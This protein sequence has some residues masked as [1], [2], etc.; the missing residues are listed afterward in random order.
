MKKKQ[1][2]PTQDAS[3]EKTQATVVGILHKQARVLLED[4]VASCLLPASLMTDRNAL[5]VGDRVELRPATGGQY[6]LI[7]VLPRATALYRGDRR[8]PDQE[9]LIAANARYL[10]VVVS[11]S[12]LLH[13]AGYIESALIAAGRAKMQ[14]AI[15]ISRWDLIDPATE[16]LLQD[17]LTLYRR[18]CSLV[19]TDLSSD[20]LAALKGNTTVLVGDRGWGK[21]SVIR[22]ILY[23]L[24]DQPPAKDP[25][26]TTHSS[27]LHA[28][29]DGT[30]LIDTPGFRDF[31]LQELTQEERSA[32]FPEIAEQGSACHFH[33]CSHRHEEGC[34]VI[35]GL[36]SNTLRRDRYDAYQKLAGTAPP[37]PK[38]DYR[39]RPC[40]ES[41]VCKACGNPVS[42]EGAGSQHRNHCP[43]C[44]CSLHVDEQTGDR[45]AVCKGIME[46]IGVWVRK[47]GEW[48][49][50]HR[51]R[52]CGALSSN[53]IAA[54]DNPA[55]LL[56]IAVKPLAMTPFPL[57]K[58]EE[59]FG[60]KA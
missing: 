12:Y 35:E 30:R 33:N 42:P 15:L 55:L 48:A 9:I 46:P 6:R 26:P 32:V 53:R 47:G 18:S 11:A 14:T 36:R 43:Y 37:A 27:F 52:L 60:S 4:G 38:A 10:L 50:I 41:F 49:I 21:S 1:N 51:C 3:I 39:H 56:S 25:I 20:L 24:D 23:K 57:H 44:L 28:L 22:R 17:K 59:V 29:K 2:H 7:Q 31:A 54:D 40:E 19:C 16:A 13:Q 8:S 34:K 58:L 5:A 45:S